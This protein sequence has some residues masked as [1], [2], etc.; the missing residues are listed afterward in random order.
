MRN[1]TVVLLPIVKFADDHR[2]VKHPVRVDTDGILVVGHAP[3]DDGTI[4][5]ILHLPLLGAGVFP[6]I[7]Y[8][9]VSHLVA[10]QCENVVGVA[11]AL[12]DIHSLWNQV[13]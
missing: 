8:N 5:C 4:A 11:R 7:Y 13:G 6:L 10:F 9:I 3:D 2:V 1:P 12:D